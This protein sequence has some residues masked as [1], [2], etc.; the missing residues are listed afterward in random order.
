MKNWFLK[1]MNDIELL[2]YD[3][4]TRRADIVRELCKLQ[5]EDELLKIHKESLEKVNKKNSIVP[6]PKEVVSDVEGYYDLLE[7]DGRRTST[8]RM[9]TQQARDCN[10]WRISESRKDHWVLAGTDTLAL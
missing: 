6:L 2:I 7:A 10:A 1:F 4:N 5:C 8:K 3:I 9:S